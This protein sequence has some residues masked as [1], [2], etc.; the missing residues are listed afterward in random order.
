MDGTYAR[1]AAAALVAALTLPASGAHAQEEAGRPKSDLEGIKPAPQPAEIEAERKATLARIQPAL[2]SLSEKCRARCGALHAKAVAEVERRY[3]AALEFKEAQ[4]AW[5]KV[6]AQVENSRRNIALYTNQIQSWRQ[7]LL[8]ERDPAARAELLKF[9]EIYERD[10]EKTHRSY[11]REREA[12]EA[13]AAA[14]LRRAVREYQQTEGRAEKAAL[15]Y[16]ECVKECREQAG[17]GRAVKVIGIAAV[18]GAAGIGISKVGGGGDGSPGGGNPGGGGNTPSGGSPRNGTVTWTIP[19]GQ[20]V[21]RGQGPSG[22]DGTYRGFLPRVAFACPPSVVFPAN[23]DVNAVASGFGT[24]GGA[25]GFSG[26]VTGNLF[27]AQLNLNFFQAGEA[28]ARYSISFPLP[29][30][31]PCDIV[32][33]GPLPRQ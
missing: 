20:E 7:E 1:I 15:E 27:N 26:A 23:L 5:T 3:R 8:R 19:L 32:Y 9:I 31:A 28:R 13:K 29:G 22:V 33:E 16:E 30:Q 14:A 2:E 6:H 11:L 18:A 10:L 25:G 17:V 21:Y 4:D 24:G 12:E